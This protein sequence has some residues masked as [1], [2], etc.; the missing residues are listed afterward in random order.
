MFTYLFS[1]SVSLAFFCVLVSTLLRVCHA[2]RTDFSRFSP[3][4]LITPSSGYLVDALGRKAVC[5][6]TSSDQFGASPLAS[7][8]SQMSVRS[9]SA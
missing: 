7:P 6:F 4:S 5:T 9:I 1:S 3:F 2:F 8:S